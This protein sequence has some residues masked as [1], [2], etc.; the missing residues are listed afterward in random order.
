MNLFQPFVRVVFIALA[1]FLSAAACGATSSQGIT[2]AQIAA[3]VKT[4]L[5]NDAELGTLPIEL[6]VDGGVVVLSG[7]VRTAEDR[8]RALA[9]AGVVSGVADVRDT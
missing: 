1:L 8:D 6:R 9:L 2:D 4:V 5:L 3:R 7:R